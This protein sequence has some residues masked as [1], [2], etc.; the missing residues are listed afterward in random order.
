MIIKII[1]SLL[2]LSILIFGIYYFYIKKE[3]YSYS[4]KDSDSKSI[5]GSNIDKYGL[6]NV[7]SDKD[8]DILSSSYFLDNSPTRHI[9][10]D[11]DRYIKYNRRRVPH[12]FQFV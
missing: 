9:K 8:E 11:Y 4:I 7:Y 5:F 3:S 12:K 6:I 2:I 1:L 10:Y